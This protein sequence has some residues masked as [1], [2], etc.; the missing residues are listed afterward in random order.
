[1]IIRSTIK[2]AGHVSLLNQT[3]EKHH[4]IALLLQADKVHII[5]PVAAVTRLTPPGRV[6]GYDI[7]RTAVSYVYLSSAAEEAL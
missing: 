4:T 7:V 2:M 1:M 3:L 6:P 5:L